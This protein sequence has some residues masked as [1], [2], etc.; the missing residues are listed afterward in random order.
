M[1]RPPF[2][3]CCAWAALALS[4]W[5][6]ARHDIGGRRCAIARPG[7]PADHFGETTELVE[8]GSGANIRARKRLKKGQAILDHMGSTELAANLFRAT[9][10]EEKLRR[11]NVQ[12][13]AAA[14]TTHEEVGKA[15]RRTI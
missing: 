15:V 3:W 2:R 8:V 4:H 10:A 9:Q 7:D 11:D 5:A 14:N 1:P 6:Y 13:R 12:G